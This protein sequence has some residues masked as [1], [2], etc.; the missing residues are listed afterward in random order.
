M[1]RSRRRLA[2][3]SPPRRSRRARRVSN[4]GGLGVSP[5][6]AETVVLAALNALWRLPPPNSRIDRAR[7][8]QNGQ[9][10]AFKDGTLLISE[11]VDLAGVPGLIRPGWRGGLGLKA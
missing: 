11:E 9:A 5:F 4:P 3:D 1:R 8:P 2:A 7:V 10:V 6:R